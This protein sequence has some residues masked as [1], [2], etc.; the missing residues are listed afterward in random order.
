MTLRLAIAFVLFLCVSGFGFAATTTQF[1]IVDA[2]NAKL[3][4]DEQFDVFWWYPSK[5]SRLHRA[6]RRL[7][8]DGS[9]LRRQGIQAAVAF[10][11][12]VLATTLVGL[13]FPGTVLFGVVGLLFLWFVYLRK[14]TT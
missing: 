8:P 7:Y 13:G 5:T 1:A 2:V 11:C 3:P 12:L 14:R 4:T 6:Y 9:L 10:F